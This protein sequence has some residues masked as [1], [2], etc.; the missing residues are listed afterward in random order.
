M[1]CTN[2]DLKELSCLLSCRESC[3]CCYCLHNVSVSR[4]SA[5]VILEDQI[6]IH[7]FFF[8][9]FFFF[10]QARCFYKPNGPVV[11]I[12]VLFPINFLHYFLHKYIG[13]HPLVFKCHFNLQSKIW[14]KKLKH[15]KQVFTLRWSGKVGWCWCVNTGIMQQ[16]FSGWN[17]TYLNHA[18]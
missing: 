17:F 8:L 14:T 9:I 10:F 16:R 18:A 5:G 13:L 3:L 4:S 7:F 1:W 15:C 12:V 11:M 6:I 2:N